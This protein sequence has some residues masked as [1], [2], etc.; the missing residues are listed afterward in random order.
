MRKN[1]SKVMISLLTLA[2]VFSL[3]GAVNVMGYEG[4]DQTIAVQGDTIQL[5]LQSHLRTMLCFRETT[6]LTIC[7]NTDLDLDINCDALKIREKDMIIEIVGVDNHRMT[8][9]CTREEAQLGLMN[10]SLHRA[11][12]RNMYRYVEGFCI[13]IACTPNSNCECTCKCDPICTCPCDCECTCQSECTCPCD[14][15]CTCQSECTCVCD[16]QCQCDPICTCECECQCICDPECKCDSECSYNGNFIKA[17]LSIRTTNQNRLGQWA[18]YDHENNE[19]VTVPTTIEDGYLT[20]EATILSTWT[21][22]N[23]MAASS[24]IEGTLIITIMSFIG[25]IAILGFYLKR[26][27]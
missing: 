15:E 20:T 7:A 2:M 27:Q 8:L 1:F 13:S 18:Y 17:R 26:R 21:I 14:C 11:R 5:Q 23:P 9:I 12:N 22:L 10:G 3:I 19:W 16:C 25:A 24:V 6:R 4:P